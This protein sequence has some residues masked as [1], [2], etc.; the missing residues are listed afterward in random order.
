ML[1]KY[2]HLVL[3]IAFIVTAFW[4]LFALRQAILPFVVGLVLVYL[5]LL[6]G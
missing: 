5:L 6:V 1:R 4:L 3:L 2:W